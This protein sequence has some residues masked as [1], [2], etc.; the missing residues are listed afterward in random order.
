MAKQKITY[1]DAQKELELILQ[2]L[3]N[4]KE[5]N[6]DHIALKVKRAAEL[7]AI[8]KKQLHE[9]DTELEQIMDKLD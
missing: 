2:E 1:S 7:I 5:I 4:E 6:M 8:C 9:I 3:E